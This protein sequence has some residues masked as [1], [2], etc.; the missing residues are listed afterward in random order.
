MP[1][2]FST[3]FEWW[4][5]SGTLEVRMR[6]AHKFIDLKLNTNMNVYQHYL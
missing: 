1:I 6:Y 5:D 4:Y 3:F 2:V